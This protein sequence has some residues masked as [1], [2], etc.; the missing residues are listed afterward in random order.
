M[1]K[2]LLF[3]LIITSFLTSCKKDFEVKQTQV[4]ENA[5]EKFFKLPPNIKP[6]AKKIYDYL[7]AENDKKEF[8]KNFVSKYGYI[9]WRYATVSQPKTSN[10]AARIESENESYSYVELPL[11][12]DNLDYAKGFIVSKVYDNGII[13]TKIISPEKYKSL[14]YGIFTEGLETSEDLQM[15]VMILNKEF[16]GKSDFEIID[17]KLFDKFLPIADQLKAADDGGR[18]TLNNITQGTSPT[19]GRTI[20][21]VTTTITFTYTTVNCWWLNHG[22]LCSGQTY[23][24][25]CDKCVSKSSTTITITQSFETWDDDDWADAGGGGS[26]GGGDNGGG[27]SCAGC[28]PPTPDPCQDPNL[29][30]RTSVYKPCDADNTG[31]T[32]INEINTSN[33]W[34]IKFADDKAY[35]EAHPDLQGAMSSVMSGTDEISQDQINA[36]TSLLNLYRDYNGNI[37]ITHDQQFFDNYIKPYIS[38]SAENNSSAT[39]FNTDFEH[40]KSVLF[41][42]DPTLTDLE[43]YAKALFNT[44]QQYSYDASEPVPTTPYDPTYFDNTVY[45]PYDFTKPPTPPIANVIPKNKFVPYRT[46]KVFYPNG[47]P[48]IDPKTGKQE[49]RGVNCLTLC[50][51][52]IAK[53][54]CI[55]TN[56]YDPGGETFVIRTN[57]NKPTKSSPQNNSGETVDDAEALKAFTYIKESLKKG[58]PV[59]VGVSTR[60][61]EKPNSD[62]VTNHF[63]VVVGYGTDS[64]GREVLR[65]YDNGTANSQEG[66]KDELTL[67]YVQGKGLVAGWGTSSNPNYDE[68]YQVTQV[69]KC[70]KK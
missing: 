19:T 22:Q 64:Q 31:I 54:G 14:P 44:N 58:I 62:N 10:T 13:Y 56:G 24:D 28:P 60:G 55:M 15:K 32:L 50:Q 3:S 9:D 39:S 37:N 2:I 29:P 33:V 52:Q 18:L 20:I 48:K 30:A 26:S 34:D 46:Y 40:Q 61:G 38:L 41:A 11:A 57:P 63:I 66:T 49:E 42:Q 68:N 47:T 53:A 5:T 6:E 4:N 1:K 21:T 69:R 35:I 43:L 45:I 70:A 67:V 27:G 8:V 25:R 16:Y 23:C 51:E 59:I 7:K 65:F 17:N 12:S 36:A